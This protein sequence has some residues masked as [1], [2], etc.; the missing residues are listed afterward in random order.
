MTDYAGACRSG[1]RNRST[2]P[3]VPKPHRK[4]PAFLFFVGSDLG[5][6]V[7]YYAVSMCFVIYQW[8]IKFAEVSLKFR[9]HSLV[10]YETIRA[11][12]LGLSSAGGRLEV[13]I[14]RC[15]R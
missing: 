11:V 7:I 10:G 15:L 9:L 3:Y 1:E 14:R 8:K 12:P 5:K 6:Y 2:A 13:G 4:N